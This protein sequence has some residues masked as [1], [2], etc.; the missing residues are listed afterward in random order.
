MEK[1]SQRGRHN[2]VFTNHVDLEEDWN[3]ILMQCH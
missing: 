2:S 3:F 1:E